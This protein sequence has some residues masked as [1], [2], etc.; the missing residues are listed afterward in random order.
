MTT[1]MFDV[2]DSAHAYLASRWGGI[3]ASKAQ[4]GPRRPPGSRHLYTATFRVA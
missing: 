1:D 4:G 3:C 2:F